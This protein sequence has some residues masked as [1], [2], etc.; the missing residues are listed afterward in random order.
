M[1][2]IIYKIG[3]LLFFCLFGILQLKGEDTLSSSFTTASKP[4]F[5]KASIGGMAP[6]GIAGG[7]FKT[8]FNENFFLQTDAFYN[9]RLCLYRK[10][11]STHFEVF[12]FFESNT[13]IMYQ[14]KLKEK[15][16][17]DLFWFVGGGMTLGGWFGSP[18][19]KTGL[20]VIIG[21]EYILKIKQSLSF[22]IDFRPGYALLFDTVY[23]QSEG[24]FFG[25]SGENLIHHFDWL[26]SF[27][28][29]RTFIE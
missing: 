28:V 13:N 2:T 22:Q 16:K 19:V 20:N 3:I 9:V 26:F 12:P 6:I 1:K 4:Y 23:K 15:Q 17:V 21:L 24:Y 5:Y 8:S 27:T 25:Y 7:S 29:R 10:N 11:S 18:N 14:E